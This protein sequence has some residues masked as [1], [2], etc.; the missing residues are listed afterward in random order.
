[1]RGRIRPRRRG[2]GLRLPAAL[3]FPA[4]ATWI[5]TIPGNTTSTVAAMLYLSAVIAAA[6][7][8]GFRGGLAASLLSFL[9]LNFFFTPPVGAF[10]VEKTED[11]VALL[12]FLVVSGLV[13]GLLTRARAERARAERREE[14]TSVL[15]H[16]ASRLLGGQ[17]LD[18]VLS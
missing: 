15:Y 17:K 14:Q 11:L 18:G 3:A 4:A 10:Q 9:G 13:A 7:V 5:G 12:A 8:A 2:F 6:F 16:L 1:M